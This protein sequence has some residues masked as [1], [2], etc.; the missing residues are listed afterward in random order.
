[1]RKIVLISDVGFS[2]P[3][4]KMQIIA[5]KVVTHTRT[6][7]SGNDTV[8]GLTD[9]IIFLEVASGFEKIPFSLIM[10][11]VSDWA[12]TTTQKP[13]ASN[14]VVY[15]PSD[16]G[17]W[18]FMRKPGVFKVTVVPGE[19]LR[20]TQTLEPMIVSLPTIVFPPNTVALA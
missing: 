17:P 14:M 2:Q 15:C 19:M 8:C 18:F 13:L 10:V 5:N 1:M 7:R 9:F 20:V 4:T 3:S 11:N 12:M 16:S 6:K